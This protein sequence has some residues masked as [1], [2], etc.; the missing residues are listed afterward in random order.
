MD[1]PQCIHT[2][3]LNI[4]KMS[5]LPRPSGQRRTFVIFVAIRTHPCASRCQYAFSSPCRALATVL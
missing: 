2:L 5:S 4:K 3:Y 1:T